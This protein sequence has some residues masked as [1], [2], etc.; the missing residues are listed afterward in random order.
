MDFDLS[1]DFV[2][3]FDLSSTLFADLADDLDLRLEDK[4][5]TSS[6]NSF[7]LTSLT[8]ILALDLTSS[9]IL[10]SYI[11]PLS[12]VI[13]AGITKTNEYVPWTGKTN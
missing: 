1:S 4:S 5:F 10:S 6:S 12:L 11:G 2:S 7:L 3:F 13:S 9:T 8:V